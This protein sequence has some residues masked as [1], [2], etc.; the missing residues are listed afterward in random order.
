MKQQREA[1]SKGRVQQDAYQKAQKLTHE[2]HSRTGQSMIVRKSRTR[3][4]TV[5]EAYGE[6]RGR[7]DRK[8]HKR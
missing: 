1:E 2:A 3:E 6:G 8:W 5:N 4:R 7:R